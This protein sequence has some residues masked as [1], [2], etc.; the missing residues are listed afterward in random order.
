VNDRNISQIRKLLE[1][2]DEKIQAAKRIL[3]E[4]VY[5]EKA[6]NLA[7]HKNGSTTIIEGI[8]D[9][10]NM[11][12][13]DGHKYTVPVNYS[14]KSKLISSDRLKLTIAPDGS[15]I[16]K[17]IGPAER[18]R[19]T[20]KIVKSGENWQIS[21]ENKKYRCLA[22]S[23]TYFKAKE[24]DKVSVILPKVGEAEWAVIENVIG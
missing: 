19:V 1:E 15:F 11:I 14:S 9:G 6:E 10:E 2:A 7:V 23:I 5:Q 20:G 24:G 13:K 21:C 18:K 8:F 22:A 12:D 4:Q 17:Q 16:F 3:F